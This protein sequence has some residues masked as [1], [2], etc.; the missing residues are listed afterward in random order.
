MRFINEVLAQSETNVKVKIF[1]FDV[2]K[3]DILQIFE[4]IFF[5]M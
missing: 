2:L 5:I 3:K 4:N 1:F